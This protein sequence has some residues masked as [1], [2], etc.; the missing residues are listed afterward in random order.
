MTN[1]ID[2]HTLEDAITW[3]AT[4]KRVSREELH[5]LC[6]QFG[7]HAQRLVRLCKEREIL[8]TGEPGV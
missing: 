7:V 6:V 5:M 2:I 1:F 4:Q 8:I 3:L